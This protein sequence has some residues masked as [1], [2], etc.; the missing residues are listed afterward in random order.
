MLES[1]QTKR[2]RF[3]R[4]TVMAV[5][6]IA[7]LVMVLGMGDVVRAALEAPAPVKPYD[8]MPRW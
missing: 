8:P 5:A 4:T 6:V 3:V 7:L 1:A 2:M